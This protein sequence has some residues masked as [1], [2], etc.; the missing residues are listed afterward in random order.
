MIHVCDDVHVRKLGCK[1]D[2]LIDF[3]SKY[4]KKNFPN[5]HKAE[6]MI[7]NLSNWIKI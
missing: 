7:C 2:L 4:G 3:K 1:N 5:H 6:Q